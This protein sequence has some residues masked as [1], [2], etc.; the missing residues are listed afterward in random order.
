MDTVTIE[1]P[2]EA[3][4]ER[5]QRAAIASTQPYWPLPAAQVSGSHLTW[6][7]WVAR[8]AARLARESSRDAQVADTSEKEREA[9]LV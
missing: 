6:P 4:S 2:A 1:R 7:E 8:L 9:A 3:L 5:P